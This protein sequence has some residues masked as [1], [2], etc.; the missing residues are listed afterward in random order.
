MHMTTRRA[1]PAPSSGALAAAGIGWSRSHPTSAG[2]G[3]AKASVVFRGGAVLTFD[4]PDGAGHLR[5]HPRRPHRVHRV[6]RRA[7][8]D[9]IG[10][11]TEIIDLARDEPMMPGIHDAHMHPALGGLGAPA[12][13]AWTTRQLTLDEM[14]DII[15]GCLQQTHDEEPDGW[16]DRQLLGLPGDPATRA[17]F[18][19]KSRPRTSWTRR[20]PILVLF[21]RRTHRARRTRERSSWRAITAST[22]DPPD[23]HDRPRRRTASRP[24]CSRT[25]RSVW[26]S[27]IIPD[28]TGGAERSSALRAAIKS[29]EPR[30]HHVVH[31]R[32]LGRE[33]TLA[34][35]A[36]A[37][38]GAG[39]LTVAGA[40]RVDWS[41]SHRPRGSRTTLLGT[42][43]A[44][45][46][47]YVGGLLSAPTVEDV[48]RR[49]DRE[50]RRTR[51]R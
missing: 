19:T 44:M 34:A 28:P 27:N 39:R 51:P 13:A 42:L 38:R 30:G 43:D 9:L 4:A 22:P 17:P 23:G 41:T 20:G 47:P 24:D 48:P 46:A 32:Q 16:L 49:R 26:S 3:R 45:R 50:A 7:S 29:D 40:A 1:V 14:R 36:N 8:A 18:P 25:R 31:E 33:S 15:A 11:A 6:G 12:R 21:A 10:P 5:G 2:R 37:A 35:A